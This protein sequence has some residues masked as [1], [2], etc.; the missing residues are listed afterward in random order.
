MDFRDKRANH[1]ANIKYVEDKLN[2][3]KVQYTKARMGIYETNKYTL[4]DI[5]AFID[6]MEAYLEGLKNETHK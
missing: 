4:I 2:G 1:L 5:K 3:Y 6:Q